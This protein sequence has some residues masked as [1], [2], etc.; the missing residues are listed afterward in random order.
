MN[1]DT[2]IVQR[3]PMVLD[4]EARRRLGQAYAFLIELGRRAR[5]QRTADGPPTGDPASSADAPAT[6][7]EASV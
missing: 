5:E 4:T 7:S 1:D 3:N 6:E 2:V